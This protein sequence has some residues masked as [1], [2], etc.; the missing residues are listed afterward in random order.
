MVSFF[1]SF[2]W[3]PILS[4]AKNKATI[5]GFMLDLYK[6]IVWIDGLVSDPNHTVGALLRLGH[7]WGVKP[8]QCAVSLGL[9]DAMLKQD[10]K[11]V[12]YLF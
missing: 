2:R 8:V 10:S 6:S 11:S 12:C 5:L 3:S 4:W 1:D 7:E 9:K